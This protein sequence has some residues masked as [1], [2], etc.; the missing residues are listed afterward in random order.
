MTPR[1]VL[2]FKEV[3]MTLLHISLTQYLVKNIQTCADTYVIFISIQHFIGG[4]MET[5]DTAYAFH[6]DS[7]L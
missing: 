3:Y 2:N 5:Y 7:I 4:I 6:V 1:S